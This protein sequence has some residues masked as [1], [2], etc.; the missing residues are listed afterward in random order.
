MTAPAKDFTTIPDASLA[1]GAPGISTDWLDIRDNTEHNYD[2]LGGSYTPAK[3]HDHDGVNSAPVAI[4]AQAQIASGIVGAGQLKTATEEKSTTGTESV[5]T[6]SSTKTLGIEVKDDTTSSSIYFQGVL[7]VPI[8]NAASTP[9]KIGTDSVGTTYYPRVTLGISNSYQTAFLRATYVQASPPWRI[10]ALNWAD[11][12]FLH[13][14]TAGALLAA[15][16]APDAPWQVADASLPKHHPARA[17]QVP[18]PF[19]GLWGSELPP[20]EEIVLVDLRTLAAEERDQPA[21]RAADILLARRSEFIALGLDAKELAAHEIAAEDQA[22]AEAAAQLAAERALEGLE[23]QRL[24]L[25]SRRGELLPAQEA[26]LTARR[27]RLRR[28]AGWVS[29]IDRLRELERSKGGGLLEL[30]TAGQLPEAEATHELVDEERSQLP[31]ILTVHDRRPWRE[32]VRVLRRP[33]LAL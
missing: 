13:R 25:V 20:D 23:E 21:R 19:C 8:Y 32:V 33:S 16:L 12:L 10:G 30:V 15:S 1:A 2:W 11:F 6:L 7:G 14:K 18:H 26:A 28:A 29:K 3:D 4:T 22:R 27:N 17:A 9:A 31:S 5:Q 24:A